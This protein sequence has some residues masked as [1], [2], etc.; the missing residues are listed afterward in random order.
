MSIN[1]LCFCW[2]STLALARQTDFHYSHKS[3]Y[4]KIN[5]K[6][7]DLAKC[8][9]LSTFTLRFTL[10]MIAHYTDKLSKLKLTN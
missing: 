6:N 8:I 9:G 3:T 4:F 7:N 10:C 5:N 1:L 2:V